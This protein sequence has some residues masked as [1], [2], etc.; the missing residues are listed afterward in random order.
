MAANKLLTEVNSFIDFAQTGF[1]YNLQIF[2]DTLTAATF[3]FAVLF[4]SPPLATL[5][6]S[7]ILLN[8]IHPMLG[9]FLSSFINGAVGS[10]DIGRCSG[11]FP[12]VSFDRLTS[13]SA[14]RGFGALETGG[15]PSY[16]NVF[17]GFLTAYV[18][19]LP[20]I[21]E[22]ELAASP[23]RRSAVIFGQILIAVVL[24]MGVVYRVGS[25]CDTFFGT[26]IGLVAGGVIGLAFS[27]FFAWISERRLTNILAF[28][29]IRDRAVDGK[30]IYV[31]AKGAVA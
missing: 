6:G 21:Y 19:T 22:K 30:P 9:G 3:L 16:Y 27:L 28:P 24:I 13:M 2:P 14:S 17:L 7:I 10:D 8:F 15:W 1:K 12:G 11:R 5:S 4:Q 20:F 26:I 29:L 25:G 23:K 18:G 31:C